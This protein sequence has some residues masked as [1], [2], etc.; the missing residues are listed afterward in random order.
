MFRFGTEPSVSD[1]SVHN[2]TIEGGGTEE[3]N[4][5]N[6]TY[7][8]YRK[9]LASASPVLKDS[10]PTQ[11]H[12]VLQD[13][14]AIV[15]LL[16]S[17]RPNLTDFRATEFVTAGGLHLHLTRAGCIGTINR[18][19]V[20]EGLSPDYV[21]VLG[22]HFSI[23]PKF[24]QQQLLH[25]GNGFN[26]EDT[27]NPLLLRRDLDSHSHE[28]CA[29]D[30]FHLQYCE[31][32][33]FDRVIEDLPFVCPM[34]GRAIDMLSRH[35]QEESTT[36][37][38]RRK[39]SWWNRSRPDGSWDAIILCDP[40]LTDVAPCSKIKDYMTLQNVPYQGGYDDFIPSP[41]QRAAHGVVKH[42][43][44]SMCIDLCYYFQHQAHHFTDHE[45]MDAT[46]S[47]TF[48]KKIVAAQYQRVT[49]YTRVMLPPLELILTTTWVEEQAEWSILQAASSRCVA[50]AGDIVG[51]ISALGYQISRRS[52]C[53]DAMMQAANNNWKDCE[54]DFQYIHFRLEALEDRTNRL[55]RSMA[56]LASIAGNRQNLEE[57]K[58]RKRLSLLIL[59]FGPLLAA[60]M[61]FTMQHQFLPGGPQFWMYAVGALGSVFFTASADWYMRKLLK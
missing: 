59:E 12:P 40:P 25:H 17:S 41:G 33:K 5:E 1:P 21:S 34:T 27:K 56:G 38:L 43:Q 44:Y 8:K 22:H 20:V 52:V 30:A 26:L 19:Y 37:V 9:A 18:I 48:I 4:I 36:A 32:R 57:A 49:E 45:W 10:D 13:G 31:L 15:V 28:P 24:F 61:F 23:D 60:S 29:G 50:Y 53:T 42:P 54:T 11:I 35:F 2:F 46:T 6:G 55:L 47:S 3:L 14:N 51:N 7:H 58:R 39:V 16:E